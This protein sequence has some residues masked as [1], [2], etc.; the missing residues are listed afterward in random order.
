MHTTTTHDPLAIAVVLAVHYA[1]R[2]PLDGEAPTGAASING[3]AVPF[4]GE[5]AY[6]KAVDYDRRA[7]DYALYLGG[8]LVGWAATQGDG[9]DALDALLAEVVRRVVCKGEVLAEVVADFYG[10]A[11]EDNE[12][13]NAMLWHEASR[14]HGGG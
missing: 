3:V 9:D 13:I 12:G 4:V 14:A 7:N 1:A 11:I 5:A 8:V 10:D 6:R 2:P